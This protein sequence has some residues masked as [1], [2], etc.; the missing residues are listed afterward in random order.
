MK[1]LTNSAESE[2][3][4]EEYKILCK[5]GVYDTRQGLTTCISIVKLPIKPCNWFIAEAATNTVCKFDAAVSK[6]RSF[7]AAE[8]SMQ[9][10][11][12]KI[13]VMKIAMPRCSLNNWP[14]VVRT[15]KPLAVPRSIAFIEGILFNGTP[16]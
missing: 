4:L 8:K 1:P 16:A 3:F 12:V 14:N 7:F 15:D 2:T 13:D 10:E 9:R 11:P 5:H 6:T